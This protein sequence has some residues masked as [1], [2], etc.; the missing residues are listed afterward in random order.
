[1]W[2]VGFPFLIGVL[3]RKF[4]SSVFN[5][6]SLKNFVHL[7]GHETVVKRNSTMTLYWLITSPFV[8][9]GLLTLG[10]FLDTNYGSKDIL[11]ACLAVLLNSS[12]C[13]GSYI[14]MECVTSLSIGEKPL[15]A[16]LR[17]DN[18]S[19]V[20]Y[21]RRFAA[22]YGFTLGLSI[23]VNSALLLSINLLGQLWWLAPSVGFICW[24]FFKLF[25]QNIVAENNVISR[26]LSNEVLAKRLYKLADKA[27]F[28]AIQLHRI[29]NEK[30]FEDKHIFV[31]PVEKTSRIHF[32]NHVLEKLSHQEIEVLFAHELG[33]LKTGDVYILGAVRGFLNVLKWFLT[34]MVLYL[35]HAYSASA[36]L[37]VA[38]LCSSGIVSSLILPCLEG[39]V[40]RYN[41]KR[42]DRFAL[43]LTG[44]PESFTSAFQRLFEIVPIPKSNFIVEALY[45][46][47]P[48]VESR[49]DKAS[50]WQAKAS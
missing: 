5:V 43:D 41:E 24:I 28:P 29:N 7:S 19:W 36:Y 13:L 50:K 45:A 46:T 47:H 4:V 15:Q 26:P 48:S 30:G 33:H 44:D 35:M 14:L 27:G 16:S 37:L 17:Y 25:L 23:I 11:T 32:T 6:D 20:V 49:I 8:I 2:C 1:M 9:Y 34:A 40:S 10:K 42:A 12:I 18:Q 38:I 22:V 39:I 21:L 31:M 3:M